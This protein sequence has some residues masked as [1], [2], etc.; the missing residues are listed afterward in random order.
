MSNFYYDTNLQL[1]MTNV[2]QF[3]YNN[4]QNSFSKHTE[5]LITHHPLNI[6]VLDFPTK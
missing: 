1:Q 4:L 6:M 3:V 5:L 2:N